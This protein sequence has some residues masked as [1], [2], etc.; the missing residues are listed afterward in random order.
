MAS[1]LIHLCVANEVNKIIKRDKIP[2]MIGS[3]APDISKYIG[4]SKNTTHFLSND[5]SDIPNLDNFLKK[6]QNFLSNDFVLGYYVHLYTDYLWFKYFVPDFKKKG[7]VK[8]IDGTISYCNSSDLEN[9]IYSDYTNLD[10]YLIDE[11]NLDL[12]I[13]YNDIP[14]IEPIIKEIDMN[15][16]NVIVNKVSIIIQNAKKNSPNIFDISQIEQFISFSSSI[17]LSSLESI[18]KNN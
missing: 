11:Y 18:D 7:Y 4:I 1:S 5:N 8:M 15:Q 10:N 6:Y 12:D 17:I 16:L 3:I 13:F 9:Y 2:F 14:T